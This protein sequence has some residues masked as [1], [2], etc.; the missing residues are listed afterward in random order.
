MQ[1]HPSYGAPSPSAQQQPN[2]GGYSGY[3]NAGSYGGGYGQAPQQPVQVAAPAVSLIDQVPQQQ[4]AYPTYFQQ[5]AP[6]AQPAPQVCGRACGEGAGAACG[7]GRARVWEAALE[8]GQARGRARVLGLCYQGAHELLAREQSSR[9]V[10]TP[11]TQ[12]L[13]VAALVKPS[14]VRSRTV[15]TVP[16]QP[17]LVLAHPFARSPARPPALPCCSPPPNPGA[18]RLAGSLHG[19]GA[20]LLLQR[21]QRRDHVGATRRLRIG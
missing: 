8:G 10:T 4:P 15:P 16:M 12:H 17:A 20:A 13:R 21:S 9:I 5:P 14:A 19:R 11:G 7:S 6:Q 1:R 2:G 18:G 3:G